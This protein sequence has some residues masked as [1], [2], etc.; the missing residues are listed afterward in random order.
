MHRGRLPTLCCRHVRVDGLQRPSGRNASPCGSNTPSTIM[1]PTGSQPQVADRDKPGRPRAP[2]PDHP[3]TK[4]NHSEVTNLTDTPPPKKVRAPDLTPGRCTDKHNSGQ[5]RRDSTTPTIASVSLSAP[6]RRPELAA[7]KAKRID[8]MA[9]RSRVARSAR[10]CWLRARGRTVGNL[11]T[12]DRVFPAADRSS[13][14]PCWRR[15]RRSAG[16]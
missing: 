9:A 7:M 1:S 10:S 12:S 8:P 3:S 2:R 6:S 11:D 16:C 13:A 15:K 14:P 4:H 5:Q